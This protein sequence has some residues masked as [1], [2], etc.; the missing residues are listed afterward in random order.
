VNL[1][2]TLRHGATAGAAA[3]AV[4]G[5]FAYLLA[6][7][8]MDR[9]VRLES[10]RTDAEHARAAAAGLPVEHHVDVFSRHTQHLGL[11]VAALGTGIALG[12]LLSVLFA[13]LHRRQD[14]PEGWRN[15]LAL[16]ASA[17]FGVYLVPFLRYPANPPGVG[18]PGTLGQRTHAYLV[19]VVIGVIGAALANKVFRDLHRRGA[20]EPIRQLAVTAVVLA[21][22]ALTFVLPANSDALTVPAGLLWQFRLLA[23]ATSAL[24]WGTLSV[25]FGLLTAGYQPGRKRARPVREPVAV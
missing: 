14:Q 3:G 18:D 7:P 15:S 22:V 13:V 23:L 5:A 16:G 25:V 1:L 24:L 2:R 21:T 10:A 8:L 17:F 11:L 20:A 4:T 12:V 19:A 9:A 6:E